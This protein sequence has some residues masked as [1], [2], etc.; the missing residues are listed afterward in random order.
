MT[1]SP[2]S[3]PR[4]LLAAIALA[5]AATTA[6]PL[7]EPVEGAARRP[8]VV[9]LEVRAPITTGTA[10][11]VEAGLE[12]ARQEQADALLV[13]LDTPGGHL[14]ATRE[15]VQH[16]LASDVPVIVW[17]GPAGARAGSAGVFITLAANVAAMHPTS[18]IGAAHPVLAGGG[19]V[20]KEAGKD[21]ARKV[22]NDTA[23]FARSIAKARGR[24][25]DWA[26]K[27]VRQ[28]VSATADEAR[29]LEV[30]DL[31]AADVPALLAA[32]DGR[33][34]ET[35]GG[36]RTLRTR[37]AVVEPLGMTV[38][39][40]T[41]GFLSDPNVVAILMLVGTLG[42]ALEFYHPGSIAP[43]AIGALCLLLAFLSMKVI[44][45]NLGAVVLLIA[46]V[47]LLVAEGY[48]TTHGFAGALGGVAIVVATLLFIDRSSAD[49]RFDPEA[50]TLSPLVVWPTPFAL[51]ALLG[52]V[53]W[54]VARSRR[55]RL[56]VGAAGM[57]GEVG[58]VTADVG[59]D[60]GQVFVHGE[61]WAARSDSPLVRGTAVRVRRVDGLV[62]RVEAAPGGEVAP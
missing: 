29:R 33:R 43:G 52:F 20:E 60:A 5:G 7:A 13:E 19:D 12:R 57:V 15:I 62:L 45:V 26:E 53:A 59:P 35:A 6:A 36:K 32:A 30:V 9:E 47:A 54:K 2:R 61:L 14:E 39:Q 18:N 4:T 8:R 22:E 58:K 38:R 56:V 46:G 17:V 34:V 25:V 11:Y 51:V 3:P 49:Y 42:I 44:P 37:D 1:T 28:S 10:E 16:L 21:M 55:E 31:V 27:A 41:L 50:F 48:V 23:A 40:R 24:N